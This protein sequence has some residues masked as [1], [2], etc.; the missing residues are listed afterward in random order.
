MVEKQDSH[1]TGGKGSVNVRG[2]GSEGYSNGAGSG[3]Q[4]RGKR[5]IYSG[6]MNNR[7]EIAAPRLTPA[8]ETAI[9]IGN[10]ELLEIGAD[11]YRK[12]L[13]KGAK[14]RVGRAVDVL[15]GT[16]ALVGNTLV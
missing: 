14:E 8:L 12:M 15:K 3:N 9:T 11:S 10:C 13:A 6:P 2:C 5:L 1:V 16:G 4:S 7:V